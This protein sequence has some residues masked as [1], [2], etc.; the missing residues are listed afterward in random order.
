VGIGLDLIPIM[1]KSRRMSQ[2]LKY[3]VVTLLIVAGFFIKQTISYSDANL[4]ETSVRTKEPTPMDLTI[5]FSI[6]TQVDKDAYLHQRNMLLSNPQELGPLL[7]SYRGSEDWTL[8]GHAAILAGWQQNRNM[9]I[10]IIQELDAINVEQESK[11]VVGISRVWDAFALKT[12]KEY[13]RAVLPL[14]WEVILK[15]SGYWPDWKTITFLRMIAAVPDA[16]SIEPVV[17]LLENTSSE[18]L[19]QVAGQTLTHLPKDL[20]KRRFQQITDKHAAIKTV[21]DDALYEMEE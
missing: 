4:S 15:F 12:E 14:A 10:R 9:Y 7:A 3:L 6:L 16:E 17:H 8:R 13:G 20:V 1:V 11:T 18:S 2:T 5:Q 19:R 21:I